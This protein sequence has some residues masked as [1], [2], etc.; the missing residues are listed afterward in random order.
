V[1]LTAFALTGAVAWGVA[2]AI[3]G[4][5]KLRGGAVIQAEP[6]KVTL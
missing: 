2:L 1:A 4:A 5:A 6:A 3:V